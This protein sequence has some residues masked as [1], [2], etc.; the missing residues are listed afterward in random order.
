MAAAD[1]GRDLDDAQLPPC[2]NE[3]QQEGEIA[4]REDRHPRLD[5]TVAAAMRQ[6]RTTDGWC[7]GFEVGFEDVGGMRAAPGLPTGLVD[8][9]LAQHGITQSAARLDPIEVLRED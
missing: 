9:Q 3:A 5:L 8:A 4:E 6:V 7:G 1:L 2:G